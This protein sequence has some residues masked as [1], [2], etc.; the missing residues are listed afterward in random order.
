VPCRA[1]L[2]CAVLQKEKKD[3]SAKKEKVGSH[4]QL[5]LH[6]ELIPAGGIQQLLAIVAVAAAGG[7]RS[8]SSDHLYVPCQC[9]Q[10]SCSDVCT[11]L[12]NV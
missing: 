12:L 5:S 8:L 7:G 3:K 1:V 4:E 6:F 10:I 9:C 11:E 2:C